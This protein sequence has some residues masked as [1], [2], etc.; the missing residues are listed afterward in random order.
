ML[1][2]YWARHPDLQHIKVYQASGV[3]KK[4]LSVFQT[5]VGMMNDDIQKAFQVRHHFYSSC[6]SP[7]YVV[8]QTQSVCTTP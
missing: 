8:P 2:D 5:Y 6:S 1:N 4:T 3:A 7:T